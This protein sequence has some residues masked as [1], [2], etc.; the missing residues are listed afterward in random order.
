MQLELLQND[1]LE[2][3]ERHLKAINESQHETSERQLS[4]K[5]DNEVLMREHG[6]HIVKQW[7]KQGSQLSR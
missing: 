7:N 5:I 6:K 3:N 4:S 1:M 2:E